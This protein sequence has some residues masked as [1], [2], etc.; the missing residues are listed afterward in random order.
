MGYPIFIISNQPDISRGFIIDGTTEK[1][2]DMIKKNLPIDDIVV[3]PHDDWHNCDCRKPKPGMIV[4]L[5][6]KFGIDLKESFLIGDNWK[7]IKAGKKVGC[8]NILIKKDY[9]KGVE[10]DYKVENLNDAVNIIRKI[11]N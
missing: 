9:N 8:K 3:C 2:N 6:K 11:I 7:D 1:I 4:S 10:A 5:S